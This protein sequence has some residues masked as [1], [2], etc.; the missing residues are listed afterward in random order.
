MKLAYLS[1]T[2]F[3]TE[4]AHGYAI[5]KMCEALARQGLEVTLFHPWRRQHNLGMARQ[6]LFSYYGL[7]PAFRV[8]PL[9]NLDVVSLEPLIPKKLFSGLFAG[10]SYLWGL[11]A[12]W[13]ARM[14]RADLHFTRDLPVAFWLT[15]MKLPT[16]CELHTLPRSGQQWLLRLLNRQPGLRLM[17]ALTSF[18]GDTLV[19]MGFAPDQVLV[20]PSGV[21]LK[22]YQSLPGKEQCRR[23]LGIPLGRRLIGY[24]GRFQT[25]GMEKGIPEV[26]R[27]LARFPA[28]YGSAPHFLCVGGPMEA[29]PAY[30]ELAGRLG[31]AKEQLHFVDRV[32]NR[33]VPL[34]IKVID[35][36]VAPY[37]AAPHY[38]HFMSPLKLFEYMAAGVPI[39]ASDLPSLREVLKHRENAWLVDPEDSE[40]LLNAIVAIL[41]NAELAR[42]LSAKAQQDVKHFAWENRAQRILD[43]LTMT[44]AQ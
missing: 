42:R 21:D 34:W 23:R 28:R 40:M 5:S 16:V 18:I 10:H 25:M 20:L 14:A 27:A 4:K 31:V 8:E 39:I 1:N 43:N 38:L 6:S 2:R 11:Y 12:A 30:L 44:A 26:I 19:E 3:P 9:A 36:A 7:P 35:L 37:P 13:R 17:V 29:V 41:G 15:R 33:E 22:A 32:P 24:I